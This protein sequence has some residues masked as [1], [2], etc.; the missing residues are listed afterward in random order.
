VG[1]EKGLNQNPLKIIEFRVSIW[2]IR[3]VKS[4]KNKRTH[5]INVK[6]GR[7]YLWSKKDLSGIN[8]L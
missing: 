7:M 4:P 5:K 6:P 3:M 2:K 8:L 1:V